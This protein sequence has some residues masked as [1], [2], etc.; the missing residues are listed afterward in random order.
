[1]PVLSVGRE[2]P[3]VKGWQAS[4]EKLRSVTDIEN[5]REVRMVGKLLNE[6]SRD[7]FLSSGGECLQRMFAE[8]IDAARNSLRIGN[9]VGDGVG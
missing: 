2:L 8:V 4:F 1:V 3:R 9:D 6:V 5:I 7:G